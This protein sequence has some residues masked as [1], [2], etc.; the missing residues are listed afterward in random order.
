MR[1]YIPHSPLKKYYIILFLLL[2]FSN[3]IKGQDASLQPLTEKLQGPFLQSPSD[4]NLKI[5]INLPDTVNKSQQSLTLD[6]FNKTNDQKV[7]NKSILEISVS[8]VSDTNNNL[9][10][11]GSKNNQIP[12]PDLRRSDKWTMNLAEG[13]NKIRIGAYTNTSHLDTT[14]TITYINLARQPALH[15]VGISNDY[16]M[17]DN[18]EDLDYA[19][20]S[21]ETMRA[22]FG[23]QQGAFF[24]KGI[25]VI[26]PNKT[27]REI[28]DT[29]GWLSE[30]NKIKENDMVVIYFANHA[31]QQAIVF[32]DSQ[33]ERDKTKNKT[34]HRERLQSLVKE[35]KCKTLLLL[36]I[37]NGKQFLSKPNIGSSPR[38]EYKQGNPT[39][40]FLKYPKADLSIAAAHG[41]AYEAKSLQNSIFVT[42]FQEMLQEIKLDEKGKSYH[43]ADK[44]RD[45]Y[46][47][48]GEIKM[49]LITKIKNIIEV[50][51]ESKGISQT[52][53]FTKPKKDLYKIPFFKVSNFTKN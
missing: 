47:D 2:F 18:I 33:S 25:E 44:D 41:D 52:P 49:F 48:F 28:K 14:V 15:F 46:I 5:K 42:A 29:M 27:S 9:T 7:N 23:N 38:K 39:D 3:N 11:R 37:C 34:I 12:K 30:S 22:I 40:F 53:A 51:Q 31:N 1:K 20:N 50:E 6:F 4:K 24:K 45:G 36:D 13:E 26:L 35:F 32:S 43:V 16:R 21:R 10:K 19:A 8:L 17:Q